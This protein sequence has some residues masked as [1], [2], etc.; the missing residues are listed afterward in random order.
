MNTDK[1]KYIPGTYAK[2]TPDATH[3]VDHYVKNWGKK[4][5]ELNQQQL[6]GAMHPCICF[7]RK[8][9]VGALEVADI[10]GERLGF[11]VADREVIEHIAQDKNLTHKTVSFFDERYPGKVNELVAFFFGEKSFVMDNYARQLFVTA[12]SIA[13]IE[14]TIFVGRGI[15]LILPRNRILSV[16][17]VCSQ[18]YRIRRLSSI[19]KV[20]EKDIEAQLVKIDGEQTAFFKKVFKK[21]SASPYEF[22]IC[23]NCDHISGY[24]KI[25]DIVH[26]AFIKKF[27][28][29][30]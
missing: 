2:R 19:L 10:L 3:L 13:A 23:I 22:D 25:A 26:E 15:H 11:S 1:I 16:R 12:F 18:E 30:L 21:Q 8:I 24:N 14:P 6:E 27:D 20:K 4:W 28:K 29:D 7:S 9:G 5:I 17:L